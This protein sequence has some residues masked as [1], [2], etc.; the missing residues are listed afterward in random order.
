MSLG[1]KIINKQNN[2]ILNLTDEINFGIL[3]DDSIP[4]IKDKLFNNKL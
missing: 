4:L 1:I 2:E 3:I